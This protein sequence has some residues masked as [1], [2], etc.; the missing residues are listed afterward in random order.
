MSGLISAL[1][2][3]TFNHQVQRIFHGR[4]GLFKGEE[5]LCLDWYPPVLLLTSFKSFLDDKNFSILSSFSSLV[6]VH[7]L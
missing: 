1:N 7:V 5:H 6:I 3:F 4:G 2:E